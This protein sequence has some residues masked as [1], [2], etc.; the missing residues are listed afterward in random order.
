MKNKQ[1]RLR[2][3]VKQLK[4]WWLERLLLLAEFG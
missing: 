2:L 1:Q 3:L 4:L